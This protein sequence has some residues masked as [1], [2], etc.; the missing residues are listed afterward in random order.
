MAHPYRAAAHKN[1]PKWVKGLETEKEHNVYQ[2]ADLKATVRD[3]TVNPKATAEA[4]YTKK[5]K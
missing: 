5:G 3:R 2:Q 4:A 1:D